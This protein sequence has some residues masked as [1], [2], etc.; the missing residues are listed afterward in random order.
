MVDE[1][2]IVRNPL[3]RAELEQKFARHVVVGLPA[4]VEDDGPAGNT[5]R[6]QVL[7]IADWY[8]QRR[9]INEEQLGVLVRTHKA[10]DEVKL[11]FI[12]DGQPRAATATLAE[13]ARWSGGS[14]GQAVSQLP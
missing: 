13:R 9:L 12:R 3:I 7:R 14:N 8:T 11:A 10:G 2:A 6:G 1:A 4:L 5:W